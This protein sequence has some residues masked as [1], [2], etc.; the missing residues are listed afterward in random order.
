MEKWLGK[1]KNGMPFNIIL[2]GSIAKDGQIVAS[3][4]F[5]EDCIV[6]T[7]HTLMTL[8]RRKSFKTLSTRLCV[9]FWLLTILKLTSDVVLDVSSFALGATEF[10]AHRPD[11]QHEPVG[12]PH[13]R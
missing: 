13:Q 7:E 6:D 10:E 5:P 4:K 3:I 8:L 1:D 12:I 2:R 9:E 11:F